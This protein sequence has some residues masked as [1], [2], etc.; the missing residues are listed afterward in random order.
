M[1]RQFRL[2]CCQ[3][4][5]ARWLTIACMSLLMSCDSTKNS[6][7]KSHQRES[8]AKRS[9]GEPDEQQDELS[10]WRKL[11]KLRCTRSSTHV[12]IV[13][14]VLGHDPCVIVMNETLKEQYH[15]TM[16]RIIETLDD[17]PDDRAGQDGEPVSPAS[18][19]DSPLHEH[20]RAS[21]GLMALIPPSRVLIHKGHAF[22]V[23]RSF[24]YSK[25]ATT[26]TLVLVIPQSGNPYLRRLVVPPGRLFTGNTHIHDDVLM[27]DL[28]MP[29][30]AVT[31][32]SLNLSD[33]VR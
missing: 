30:A 29:N 10:L 14:D 21:E 28:E 15:S 8:G 6:V 16:F 2:L 4:T 23:Y 32:I 24:D 27:L 18:L 26:E 12:D 33:E 9:V 22:V 11:S 19:L 31:Q 7:S 5:L 20:N 25:L 3:R 1:I 17:H 13:K